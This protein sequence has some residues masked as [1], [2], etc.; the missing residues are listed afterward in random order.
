M[1]I[2]TRAN[3]EFMV[4]ARVSP[5]LSAAGMAV[6]VVGSNADLNDPLGHAIRQL[7]HTVTDPTAVADAD[8]AQV[9]VSE[10]DEFLDLAEL[11]TCENILGHLDDVNIHVGPRWEYLS[12]LA[13]QVERK[14]AR[15][16]AA[17]E[18]EYGYGFS[19][20]AAG[21]IRKDIAEHD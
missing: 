19:E 7:G 10:T 8:V 13:K 12:D 1:T 20:A 15:L 9:T 5:L 11:Y 4:F 6:A 3:A 17:I 21:Y 16:R 2:S 14:I 18:R